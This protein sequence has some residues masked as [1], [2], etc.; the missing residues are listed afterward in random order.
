M[1]RRLKRV[2][3]KMAAGT[4]TDKEKIFTVADLREIISSV[5]AEREAKLSED[6]AK[7]LHERLAE[8]FRD[9]TKFNEDYVTRQLRGTD[10]AYLS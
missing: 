8:Q 3:E 5:L 9:F 1:P 2:V 6:F 7:I 10:L 4:I